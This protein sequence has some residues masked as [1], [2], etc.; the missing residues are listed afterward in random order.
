MP[1]GSLLGDE[2]QPGIGWSGDRLIAEKE[3]VVN[4]ER[5][6][7]I[8]ERRSTYKEVDIIQINEKHISCG[9]GSVDNLD[10]NQKS[11]DKTTRS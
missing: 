10:Q 9:P 5:V 7:E 3:Q 2:T 4:A 11:K 8:H 6:S 1:L